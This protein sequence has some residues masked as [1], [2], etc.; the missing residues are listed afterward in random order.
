MSMDPHYRIGVGMDSHAFERQSTGRPLLL[1]GVIFQGEIGLAGDSDADVIL[2]ALF[3]AIHSALGKDGL[4]AYFTP[5]DMVGEA[6]H[7]SFILKKALESLHS[8]PYELENVS[9]ALEC[10]TPRIQPKVGEIKHNLSFLLGISKE[11]I[12]I[13][14]G[15]GDK[16]TEVAR[17]EGIFCLAQVLLCSKSSTY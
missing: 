15:T 10:L 17:G 12:G 4:G 14:A 3:N 7:S 5:K 16:L 11:K 8:S 9:I 13:T 6:I 1:G 2:H